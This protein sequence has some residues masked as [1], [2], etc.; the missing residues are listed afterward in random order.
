MN[1]YPGVAC[2]TP[3][4]LYTF[5]WDPKADWSHYYAYGPEIRQYFEDFA[6]KNGCKEFIKFNTRLIEARWHEEKG[7]WNFTVENQTT[8]ERYNDWCHV[9]INAAGILNSW[10]WPEVPGLHDFAGPKVHSANWDE[11]I[12]CKGKTVGIVGNGST[13]IQIVPALQKEVKHMTVFM[14]SPTWVAPPF[15]TSALDSDILKGKQIDSSKRQHK[16]TEEEKLRFKNDPEYY[17]TFRKR[18][19]A[20]FNSIIE[21]FQP[22]TEAAK[23]AKEAIKKEMLK[24]IGNGPRSEELKKLLIPTWSPGC[25]RLSPGDSYLEALSEPN[26]RPLFGG[27]ERIVSDGVITEDGEHVKFDILICATGFKPAFRPVFPLY[28]RD[29][30][31]LDEDWGPHVNLYLGVSAPRFPN[32]FT[33][34]GPGSTW[35]A[36]SLLP[37]IEA[38]VE[39]ALKVTKKIQQEQIRS[40]EV[41]Q[42]AVDDLF[43]HFDAFH[44]DTVFNEECRSWYKDG[45]IKNRIYQWPGGTI[46]HVKT[47]REPRYEDY[48]MRYRHGNRFAYLGNGEIKANL[49][50]DV[51]GLATYIRNSDHEWDIE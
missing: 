31:S 49:E 12:D 11:S 40:I 15:G 1:R 4:S 6:N 47:I 42:E 35:A 29:G 26:V 51:E 20:E 39:Y 44:A 14:R 50:G 48:A 25:R 28:G 36:G 46:H 43:E 19:E 7:Y 37:S 21:I 32:Y 34:A 2:D 30:K 38:G 3:A 10:K 17:L 23:G 16:F 13:G 8:K 33:I 27:L 41:R 24:R 45:K 18:L 22:K 5:S 9:L